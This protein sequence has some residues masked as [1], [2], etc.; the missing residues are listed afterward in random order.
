VVVE[1]AALTDHLDR[2]ERRALIDVAH[3]VDRAR[4]KNVVTNRRY[5]T[6]GA[7][8]GGGLDSVMVVAPSRLARLAGCDKTDCRVCAK[9]I[10]VDRLDALVSLSLSATASRT[11]Q[12]TRGQRS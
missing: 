2:R 12:L 9:E 4:N 5:Q 10:R 11:Y 7:P 1:L 8:G 6:A 3:H